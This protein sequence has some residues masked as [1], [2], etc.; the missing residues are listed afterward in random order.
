MILNFFIASDIFT[1]RNENQ[2]HTSYVSCSCIGALPPSWRKVRS[3]TYD[4]YW[5]SDMLVL[6]RVLVTYRRGLNL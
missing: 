5:L 4:A 2:S 6:S 1:T 3:T